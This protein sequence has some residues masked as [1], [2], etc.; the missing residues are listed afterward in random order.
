MRIIGCDYHPGFQQPTFVDTSGGLSWFREPEKRVRELIA[1]AA[2]TRVSPASATEQKQHH[3][4]NQY[5]FHCCTS[6]VRGSWT[7]LY[8]GH[9]I[10]S[11]HLMV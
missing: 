9:L 1:L 11:L 3:K 5:G 6:L 2:P 7:D 8:N 4:N 10:S